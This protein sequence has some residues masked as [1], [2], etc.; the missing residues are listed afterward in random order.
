M[1]T[2]KKCLECG[3]DLTGRSTF[4]CS[5]SCKTSHT[6][7]RRARGSEMYDLFMA[8][9]YDRKTAKDLGIWSKLCRMAE[10]YND[11]DKDDGIVSAIPPRKALQRMPHL[12]A[13]T[14]IKVITEK[15]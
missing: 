9:R 13:K 6:N 8:M 7:R 15:G 12:N 2:T 14:V 4:F 1:A 11:A 10:I 3:S 5:R